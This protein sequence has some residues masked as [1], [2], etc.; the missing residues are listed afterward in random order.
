MRLRYV[1][2][3]GASREIGAATGE[4]DILVNGAVYT[5][6]ADVAERA[7]ASSDSWE[8]AKG[9]VTTTPDDPAESEVDL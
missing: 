1:G 8:L 7:L 4:G 6:P 2:S 5:L 9:A 3:G